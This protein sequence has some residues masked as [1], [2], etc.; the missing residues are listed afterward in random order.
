RVGDDSLERVRHQVGTVGKQTI[1][2]GG[3]EDRRVQLIVLDRPLSVGKMIAFAAQVGGLDN[4]ASRKFALQVPV[5][6]LHDRV[7]PVIEETLP[8]AK[9]QVRAG[10]AYGTVYRAQGQVEAVGERVAQ[11]RKDLGVVGGNR[12]TS[13]ALKT[14]RSRAARGAGSLQH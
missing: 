3:V 5:P 12:H 2:I 7:H 4:P 1:A 9:S 14:L 8:N 10:P 6:L 11:R 13:A